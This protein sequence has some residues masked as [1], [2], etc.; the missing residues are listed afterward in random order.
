MRIERLYTPGLA[1]VAY[2]VGDEQ[3]GVAALIDPRR[4]VDAYLELARANGLR[5]TDV[6]ETHI[7]AD[8][9]SGAPELAAATG[10]TL[11]AGRLGEV[12]YP[13]HALDDGDEVAVGG[14]RVR[15]LHTPGHTPEHL[16]YF[17][18][19]PQGEHGG[20]VAPPALFSGDMLFVGEVGR[21]DL[22]GA[23]A[24][25]R[26]AGQLFDSVQRL[27]EL[28]DNLIVY[29][30][31]GAG[32]ACGKSIGDSPSTTI[33]QEK[34]V[35]YAFQIH[36]RDAFKRAI[37]EGMPPAPTYYP[38]LKKLNKAGA[39][40]LATLP[41]ARMLAVEEVKQAVADGALLLDTRSPAAFGG[42][43]IAGAL[44]AG[45]GPNFS[46]W[47]GW[48]APYEHDL[49]LV[50]ERDEDLDEALMQLRRIGL[51]RV[52]GALAGGLGAWL[53]AGK[54]IATLPQLDV[55]TLAAQ[56]ATGELR[57]LDVR[58]DDEWRS[59]HIAGA[60]HLFAGEI[61]RAWEA[62]PPAP[63]GQ[64]APL[65]VICGSGYRSSVAASVLQ[66]AGR[67]DLVN[68]IGGMEAWHA[69]GLATVKD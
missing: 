54:P 16:C 68:V 22:L 21:P 2:L 58:N 49:V 13:H 9:V 28:P 5:I 29:P 50:L 61:A 57:L 17:V 35:N 33:G 67:D 36:E 6:F 19:D 23:E 30:G 63:N 3:A 27:R 39:P 10:A 55:C 60:T 14:L 42:A 48:L 1:Q 53:A 69:A 31:H 66:R 8:F 12:D 15:A 52:T 25:D 43:H 32:S 11:H 24:T 56:L 18:T 38:I 51:D 4:D 44:F 47:L 64:G 37:L 45:L 46:A 62:P 34:L 26:L 40:L 20:S 59:G 65:A 41:A 7:H